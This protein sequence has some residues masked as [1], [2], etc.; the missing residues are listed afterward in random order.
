[1]MTPTDVRLTLRG[2][3]YMP[4]ALNGKKPPLR[5]WQQK[6]ETNP[7][8]IDLWATTYPNANNT[9]VLTR[10]TPTLDIDIFDLDAAAAVE[11]LVR[12]RFEDSGYVLTRIGNAPK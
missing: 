7:A 3:G 4:V 10:F 8:E 5:G 11:Q 9:G 1:M 6:L 12:D 2:R